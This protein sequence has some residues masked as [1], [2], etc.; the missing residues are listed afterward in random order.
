MR[1]AE[2]KLW[3][4]LARTKNVV[5]R[6]RRKAIAMGKRNRRAGLGCV[7]SLGL[8]RGIIGWVGCK[9]TGE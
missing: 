7:G 9:I 2:K 4:R 3:Y 5:H 1:R 6:G 8:E